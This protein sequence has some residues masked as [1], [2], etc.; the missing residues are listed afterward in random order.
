MPT[1]NTPSETLTRLSCSTRMYASS[2]LAAPRSRSPNAT[3]VPTP[4]TTNKRL[5]SS[6]PALAG[7]RRTS[8]PLITRRNLPVS[9][10]RLYEASGR[11]HCTS[12]TRSH[13]KKNPLL[14]LGSHRCNHKGRSP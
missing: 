10:S 1:R 4:S 8:A 13:R 5:S 2:K 7:T 9:P 14:I 6:I 12:Q 3:P 11:R